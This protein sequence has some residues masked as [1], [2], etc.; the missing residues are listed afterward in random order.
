MQHLNCC[1]E[2]NHL[3][4]QALKKSSKTLGPETSSSK[5]AGKRARVIE[6]DPTEEEAEPEQPLVWIL[7][8]EML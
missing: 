5:S 8:A 4:E 3:C 6:E 1:K 2:S 7:N